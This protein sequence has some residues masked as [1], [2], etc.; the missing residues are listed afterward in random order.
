MHNIPVPENAIATVILESP[1]DSEYDNQMRL[2]VL[3]SVVSHLTKNSLKNGIVIFPAGMFYS[4]AN[5]PSSLY[6][7][8]EPSISAFLAKSDYHIVVCFGIDGSVDNEGYARDQIAVAADKTGIIALGKK[9]YPAKAERGHVNLAPDFNIPEAGKSRIF[10]FGNSLYY[11]GMCYDGF[12]IKNLNI[13]NPG[14]NGFIELAHCFYPKGQGPSGESYFARHGFAGAARQWNCPVFGT[15]VFFGREVPENWPT[16]V[17]WNQGSKSTTE[18]NYS[19]NTLRP[20]KVERIGVA[21][22]AAV[23]RH[24]QL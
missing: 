8:I 3:Q 19:M 6:P 7:I 4:A 24:Y 13:V 16:G 1:D 17:I 22:G 12:G 10:R 21:D 18:W 11:L 9:F 20:L 14:V 23:I 2:Q 5:P 15:A